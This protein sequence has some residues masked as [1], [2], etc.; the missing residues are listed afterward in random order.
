M[1]LLE[2]EIIEHKEI[3]LSGKKYLVYLKEVPTKLMVGGKVE[4]TAIKAYI[5]KL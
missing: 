4:K 2:E 1:V 5:K 3:E